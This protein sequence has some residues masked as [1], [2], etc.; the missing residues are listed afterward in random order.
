[1]AKQ[2]HTP[3]RRA[4]LAGLAAAPV[5]GLPAIAGVAPNFQKRS[6]GQ[7]SA[8]RRPILL[9][10]RG[11]RPTTRRSMRSTSHWSR[12]GMKCRWLPARPTPSCL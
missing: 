1:M 8:T 6:Q 4:M 11:R 5:A 12:L 3:S 2:S 9:T 10:G 7:S